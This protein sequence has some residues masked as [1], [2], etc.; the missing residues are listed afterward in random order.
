LEAA[1]AG[2]KSASL[3]KAWLQMRAIRNAPVPFLVWTLSVMPLLVV[4]PMLAIAIAAYTNE[5]E[6]EQRRWIYTIAAV[7]IAASLL[8]WWWAGNELL[9]QFS[10]LITWLQSSPPSNSVSGFSI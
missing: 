9:Q 7:N 3:Q 8:F 6:G 5:P 10:A 1:L 2:L 4:S